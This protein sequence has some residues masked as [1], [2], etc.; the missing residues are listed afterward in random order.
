[1][2]E[3]F[4]KSNA[5]AAFRERDIAASKR[6]H[7]KVREHVEKHGSEASDYVKSVVFGG[8]DGIMTVFAIVTASAGGNADW[9]TIL[10]FGFSN[11]IADAFSMG[12]G[13]FVSGDA[14]RDHALMERSR[15]AWEV[16]NC[17]EMEMQEM[18][19]VYQEK[20]INEEDAKTIVGIISK[21]PQMFVDFMMIDELGI[22][23]DVDDKWGPLKQ[24]FVMFLSF[25][26]FGSVPLIAYLGGTGKGL[27][28]VF[29]ISCFL[30]GVALVILGA[31]SGYLT[32]VSIPKSA[33]IMV[34][35]GC[36]SGGVS[37]G[38]SS[39]VGNAIGN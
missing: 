11:V 29:A 17:K 3:K 4:D 13:E 39:M 10:V 15:E 20:G 2:Q 38:V 23:I 14:E 8:L 9:Q 22:L 12:F 24:G 5:Q 25:I 19:E 1:M 36:V 27:D 35:N 26:L 33:L 7:Q 16:E 18:V 34:F 30:T 21:D 32:G 31:L 6:E 37:F 28:T